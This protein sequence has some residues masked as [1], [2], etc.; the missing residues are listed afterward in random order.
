MGNLVVD[1]GVRRVVVG[2]DG[3]LGSLQAL[4]RAVTEARLRDREVWSV[5]AWSPP[6]GEAAYRR[7]PCPP[8]LREWRDEQLR[9][10]R[11]AWDEALGGVPGDLDVSLWVVRGHPGRVL[12]EFAGHPDDLLL[13]GTGRRGRV[14]RWRG[15]STLRHCL[16]HARC[17][18]V[19]VPPSTLEEELTGT[20]LRRTL[21]R[22]TL[23]RLTLETT[24]G[25]PAA[26]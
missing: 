13:V 5:L 6:G 22:R 14:R 17:C 24:P 18:V 10:L 7:S 23:S 4:R 20:F 3:S 26:E 12:V 8:L 9:R 2:V 19:A 21:T 1:E 15:G 11:Q 25:T 16:A